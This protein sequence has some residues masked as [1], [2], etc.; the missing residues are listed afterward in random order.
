MAKSGNHNK[1]TNKAINK[2]DNTEIRNP[3]IQE[4]QFPQYPQQLLGGGGFQHPYMNPQQQLIPTQQASPFGGSGGSSSSSGSGG[5]L[6]GGKFNMQEIKAFIDR[7]GGI[8]GIIDTMGKVNKFMQT[9]QQMGPMF[10]LLFSSFGKSKGSSS[11]ADDPP[12]RRRS[13]KRK[14]TYRSR[15]TT[16]TKSRRR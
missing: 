12:V 7:M 4:S 6:F 10:K 15:R 16:G 3:L 1:E 8:E 9:M 5:G 2:E 13:G 11:R 14:S